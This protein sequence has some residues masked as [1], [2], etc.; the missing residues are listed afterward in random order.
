MYHTVNR[1]RSFLSSCHPV[2]WSFDNSVIWS[3]SHLVTRLLHQSVTWS[4]SHSVTWSLGHSVTWSLSHSVTWSQVIIPLFSTLWP[5]YWRT[6]NI[7][8]YRSTSQT[9]KVRS[10]NPD[11]PHIVIYLIH[12]QTGPGSVWVV[13]TGGRSSQG[14]L[15]A[16]AQL[17]TI[18]QIW[19]EISTSRLPLSSHV[20]GN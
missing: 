17:R 13:V 19:A 12:V 14:Q 20:P 15:L 3:F 6:D 11:L 9:N 1:L 18:T 16:A 5:T 8:T 10:L 7:R 4:L 2:I